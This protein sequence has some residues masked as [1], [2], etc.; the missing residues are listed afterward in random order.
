MEEQ[1][2][3]MEMIQQDYSAVSWTLAQHICQI[4]HLKRNISSVEKQIAELQAKLPEF[5]QDQLKFQDEAAALAKKLEEE[6]AA[7]A[8]AAEAEEVAVE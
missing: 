5:E 7:E 4:N 8:K 2:R 6:K 3:T 1:K